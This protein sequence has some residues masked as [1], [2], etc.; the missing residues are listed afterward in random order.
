MA[1]QTQIRQGVHLTKKVHQVQFL[2]LGLQQFLGTTGSKVYGLNS[3]EAQYM[4]AS[5]ATCEVIG[6]RKILMGLFG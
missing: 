5:Q 2:M 3:I 1:S 6:M 4:V